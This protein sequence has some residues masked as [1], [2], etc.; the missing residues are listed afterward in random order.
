ML[1]LFRR[2]QKFL[3]IIVTVVVVISFSF[4]GTY[5]LFTGHEMKDDVAFEAV[6]G[7]FVKRSELN[8]LITLISATHSPFQQDVITDDILNTTIGMNLVDSY[9]P[10]M[11]SDLQSRFE[12]EKRYT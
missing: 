2:Y 7:S 9:L 11:Q 10:E 3:F 5:S 1:E 12:K 6:D 4:Y 8:D